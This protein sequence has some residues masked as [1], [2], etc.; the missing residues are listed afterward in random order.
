[1][2][3]ENKT[4]NLLSSGY[5]WYQCQFTIGINY[6]AKP[7]KKKGGEKRINCFDLIHDTRIQQNR[8]TLTHSGPGW[9][10]NLEAK[11][12]PRQ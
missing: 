8:K 9:G 11:G 6:E 2:T 7:K 3:G 12:R 4:Q 5:A 10:Q 1:M